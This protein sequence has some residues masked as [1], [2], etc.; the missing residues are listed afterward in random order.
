[1]ASQPSKTASAKGFARQPTWFTRRR[2]LLLTLLVFLIGGVAAA[3]DIRLFGGS[4]PRVVPAGSTVVLDSRTMKT[5]SV[6]AGG[7]PLPR[8]VIVWTHG[9]R[10]TVDPDT[11]KLIGRAPISG[12]VVRSVT[13]GTAPVAVAAGFGSLWVANNG[14]NSLTR[15]ALAGSRVETLGLND[16][17]SGIGTG[18]GYVWVLSERSKKVLRIDPETNLVTKSVRFTQPPLQ[19]AV[20]PGR[21]DLVMGE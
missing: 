20:G 4:A 10:W 13:V 18:G 3:L 15:V 14:N 12:R 11:N 16:Q 21:V 1:L 2:L 9:V 19:V 8:S 7:T 6:T 17:P 5:R